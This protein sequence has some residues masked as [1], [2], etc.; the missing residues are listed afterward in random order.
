[1][2]DKITVV[3]LPN[4]NRITLIDPYK[5]TL[6]TTLTFIINCGFRLKHKITYTNKQNTVF[7]VSEILTLIPNKEV[8]NKCSLLNPNASC[9]ICKL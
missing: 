5:I 4:F 3:Y 6:N 2:L 8:K 1:M 9:R 7:N